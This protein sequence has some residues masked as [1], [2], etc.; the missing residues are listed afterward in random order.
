MSLKHDRKTLKI[1]ENKMKTI[2][3]EHDEDVPNATGEHDRINGG[4]KGTTTKTAGSTE[5][6]LRI[7]FE[8]D[9]ISIG[10]FVAALVTRLY[11]LDEP[12]NIV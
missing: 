2:H 6:I 11:R 5:K 8:I 1:K 12:K 7:K 10:L 9:L 3:F 4:L